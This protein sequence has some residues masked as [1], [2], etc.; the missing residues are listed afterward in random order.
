[1]KEQQWEEKLAK[2]I[3]DK[4]E[5]PIDKAALDEAVETVSKILET[6]PKEKKCCENCRHYGPSPL[7]SG[8]GMCD[9]LLDDGGEWIET[10]PWEVCDDF[11]RITEEERAERD[12]R[13]EESIEEQIRAEKEACERE[14]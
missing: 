13:L 4:L 14:L 1:M 12:K 2:E 8:E 6:I 3:E 11:N 10:T 9:K 7:Y 5:V